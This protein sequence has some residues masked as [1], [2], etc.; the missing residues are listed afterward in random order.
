MDANQLIT[1]LGDAAGA[2]KPPQEY[3]FLWIDWWATCMTKSEWSGWMQAIFSVVAILFSGYMVRYQLRHQQLM[4]KKSAV[5]RIRTFVAFLSSYADRF[6]AI[7]EFSE[8]EMKRQSALLSEH[9]AL[10]SSIPAELLNLEWISALEGAR[11]IAVQFRVLADAVAVNDAFGPPS[12][13]IA[14]Q[15][16]AALA[17]IAKT[18]EQDH[19]GVRVWN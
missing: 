18:V 19:P 8:L 5:S 12:R 11:S 17:E 14:Q 3:C 4:V 16:V 13:P 9:V 6:V 10:A 1:A 7:T 2:A 15:L